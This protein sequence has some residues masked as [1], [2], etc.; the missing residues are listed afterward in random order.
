MLISNIPPPDVLVFTW[1]KTVKVF[2]PGRPYCVLEAQAR[3]WEIKIYDLDNYLTFPKFVTVLLIL[4]KDK[5]CGKSN[6][7]LTLEIV[8]NIMMMEEMEQNLD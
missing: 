7:R 8:Y 6:D 2:I 4:G 3:S 5:L 1:C